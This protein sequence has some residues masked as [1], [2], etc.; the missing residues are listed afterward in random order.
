MRTHFLFFFFATSVYPKA[1][2]VLAVTRVAYTMCKSGYL[3]LLDLKKAYDTLD[4]AFL[5]RSLL[6]LGLPPH[7]ITLIKTLHTDTSTRLNINN[8]LGPHIPISSGVRQGCP[9]APQLF[10]CA[11]EMLTRLALSQLR[12]FYPTPSCPKLLS[13]YA[14]DI[15]FYCENPEALQHILQ[16]IDSFSTAINE[17]PNFDMC[18]IL[19][20]GPA[21]F[22][23]WISL[24]NIPIIAH[25]NSERVLGIFLS[26]S[27]TT[28]TTWSVITH[29]IHKKLIK[30]R[31]FYPTSQARATIVNNFIIPK[32]SF[33]ARFHPPPKEEWKRLKTLLF[34]FVSGN[35]AHATHTSFRIWSTKA[36]CTPTKYGG[37]GCS[38]CGLTYT[39]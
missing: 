21:R 15:T 34:N 18:A 16:C 4:R 23:S 3:F 27:E 13:C 2:R 30:W 36:I 8:S 24:R 32:F 12:P 39:T 7:F 26:P 31:S 33:Q 37:L 9:I 14:D 10:I 35:T 1:E 17:H 5:L 19:P 22:A 6:H 28:K 11:I 20:M 29:G 38:V 25:D